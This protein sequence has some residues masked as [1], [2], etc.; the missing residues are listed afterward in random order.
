VTVD[1]NGGSVVV[2]GVCCLVDG[3]GEIVWRSTPTGL[4]GCESL[5]NV[6]SR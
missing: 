1:G 2:V 6:L 5:D 4:G 3:E